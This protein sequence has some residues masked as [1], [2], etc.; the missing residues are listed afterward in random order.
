MCGTGYVAAAGERNPGSVQ[1]RTPRAQVAAR[2]ARLKDGGVL[3]VALDLKNFSQ[4]GKREQLLRHAPT[5]LRHIVVPL[6]MDVTAGRVVIVVSELLHSIASPRVPA[7]APSRCTRLLLAGDD[8]GQA[9]GSENP[10]SPS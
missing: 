6:G 3:A 10:R 4:G 1:S 5:L 8:G 2:A 9:Y 7:A